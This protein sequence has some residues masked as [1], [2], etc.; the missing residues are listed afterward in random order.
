ME[1]AARVRIPRRLARGR[2]RQV[3]AHRYAFA[4]ADRGGQATRGICFNKVPAAPKAHQHAWP[5]SAI[6]LLALHGIEQSL[7]SVIGGPDAGIS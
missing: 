1:V 7:S 6:N 3:P 5:R 2:H 4:I